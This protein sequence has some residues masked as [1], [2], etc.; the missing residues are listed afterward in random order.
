MVVTATKQKE[1]NFPSWRARLFFAVQRQVVRYRC[2]LLELG[3][4]VAQR[5]VAGISTF[6]KGR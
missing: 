6:E 1:L 3:R 2:C 5:V 4:A